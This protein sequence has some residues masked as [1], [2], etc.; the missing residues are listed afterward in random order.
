M[1]A[2]VTPAELPAWCAAAPAGTKPVVLDVREA[3]EVATASVSS[4]VFELLNIPMGQLMARIDDVPKDRPIA[5]L[6]HHGIRSRQVALYLLQQGYAHT[7]NIAG[8]T[9]AWSS[10]DPSLPRY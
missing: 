6:C 7:V 8:G 9:D 4:P 10:L 2:Q 1:L 3:W 5:C